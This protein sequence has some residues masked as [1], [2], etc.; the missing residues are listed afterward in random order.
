MDTSIHIIEVAGGSCFGVTV[1]LPKTKLMTIVAP[2]VGYIM[3][4]VLNVPAMDELHGERGIIAGR[5]IRVKTY[6]DMLKAKIQM[7]TDMGRR[8]GIEVGMTGG[9]ALSKMLEHGKKG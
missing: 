8:I 2:D 7:V 9:E 6:E 3:C 5:V 1:N 4:G